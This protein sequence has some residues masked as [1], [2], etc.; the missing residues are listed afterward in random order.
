MLLNKAIGIGVAAFAAALI[1][2]ACGGAAQSKP[3]TP[4][5]VSAT[6]EAFDC[7]GFRRL[8]V[9]YEPD[10]VKVAE[11]VAVRD[12]KLRFACVDGK[13]LI[14]TQIHTFDFTHIPGSE[15]DPDLQGDPQ[16]LHDTNVARAMGLG[17]TLVSIIKNGREFVGSG[18]LEGLTFPANEPDVTKVYYWTDGEVRDPADGFNLPTATPEQTRSEI[19]RWIPRLRGLRGKTVI[20]IGGGR[21]AQ[22][23]ATATKAHDLFQAI[24][25]NPRVRGHLVWVPTL[26][27][28]TL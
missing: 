3:K 10:L 2:S 28:V 14:S 18:L 21:G 25:E 4:R 27:Q 26:D 1:L 23:E 7:S 24:I 22:T 11:A 6:Y 15:N 13:P 17:P 20:I 19:G 16:T 9:E 12:D 5:V 8:A